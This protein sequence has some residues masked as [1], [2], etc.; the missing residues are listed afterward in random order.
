MKTYFLKWIEKN[1]KK[2]SDKGIKWDEIKTNEIEYSQPSTRVDLLSN[3]TITRIV[4]FDSGRVYIEVLNIN[5]TET[6]YIFDDYINSE[7]D[8]E[9]LLWDTINK[10]I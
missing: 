2:I 8:F 3:N 9:I 7:N 6:E 1:S 10:M 5:T 4:A